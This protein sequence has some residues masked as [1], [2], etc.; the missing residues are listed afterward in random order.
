VP[1]RLIEHHDGVLVLVE[2]RRE[3]IEEELHRL[4]VGVRQ[5][6]RETVVR[7]GLYGRED[8]GE[9]EALVAQARRSLAPPPPDVAR[10]AL[11]PDACLVLEEEAE[12]LRFMRTLNFSEQR[13]GSF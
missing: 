9:R 7:A 13:R 10:P 6:E 11:L 2:R 3:A 8:V 12:A 5:D 1:T 4:G